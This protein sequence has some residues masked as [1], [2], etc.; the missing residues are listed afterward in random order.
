MLIQILVATALVLFLWSV[1]RFAMGLRFAKVSRE[2][3]R[4]AEEARGRRVVTEI[5][6]PDDL[7][8]FLEDAR[9][10]YWGANEAGKSGIVGARVLL[11]GGVISAFARN[12]F[13]LP[14]PPPADEH[15]GRERWDVLLYMKDGTV[16]TVPCGALRE[17]VSREV[18]ARIFDAVRTAATECA[19][20]EA[21][22]H[23]GI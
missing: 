3:A 10:F 1:F 21:R 15:E 4:C 16:V 12:G 22:R 7:L 18:A 5:P 2:E 19:T 8:F 20:T 9:G 17:G 11:N 13:A 14:E 23:G 6:L